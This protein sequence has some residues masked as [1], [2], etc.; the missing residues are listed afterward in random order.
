MLSWANLQF[1]SGTILSAALAFYVFSKVKLKEREERTIILHYPKDFL[2]FSI[3]PFCWVCSFVNGWNDGKVKRLNYFM[4]TYKRTNNAAFVARAPMHRGIVTMTI[5]LWILHN[6]TLYFVLVL[7]LRNV[8]ENKKNHLLHV[9]SVAVQMV[10]R[11]QW[12]GFVNNPFRWWPFRQHSVAFSI[13]FHRT[14]HSFPIIDVV[15]HLFNEL[16]D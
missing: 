11:N 15:S 5:S 12:K 9:L 10:I 1:F 4:A 13:E 6:F 16:F 14:S 8:G 2:L 3:S 7:C